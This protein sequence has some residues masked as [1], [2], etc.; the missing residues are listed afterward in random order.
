MEPSFL[1]TSLNWTQMFLT[2][3]LLALFTAESMRSS[4]RLKWFL[5]NTDFSNL[6][7]RNNEYTRKGV[8]DLFLMVITRTKSHN[9]E[10]IS[11]RLATWIDLVLLLLTKWP[12]CAAIGLS[13]MPNTGSKWPFVYANTWKAENNPKG[14]RGNI[15]WGLRRRKKHPN[16]KYWVLSSFNKPDTWRLFFDTNW[17][18]RMP[19]DSMIP[20]VAK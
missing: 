15:M 7:L 14:R 20:K 4:K 11:R 13:P 18:I 1:A 17:K 5:V 10:I 3:G 12:T 2:V 19:N 8:N 9:Q 16:K 6:S